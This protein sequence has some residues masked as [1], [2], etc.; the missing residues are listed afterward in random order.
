MDRMAP[1][2][3]FFGRCIKGAAFIILPFA[4]YFLPSQSTEAQITCTP[5]A[6][7][8]NVC[9]FIPASTYAEFNGLEQTIR[10]QYLN[11]LTKSMADASVLANINS[12]MMGPGTVNRFQIGG[13]ISL[14]GVKKDDV[15][16]QYSDISLPKFPNVGASINPGAMV[17]VNLG[18]LL[19][20]GPSDQPDQ[21]SDPSSQRS[22]LHRINIYAHGFQGN[23]GPGDLRKVSNTASNDLDVGGNI[24]SFGATIRFQIAR[25]RYTRL[26]FFGFTGISLGIGFHRKW[27]EVT[28]SYHP[29]TANAIK[30]AFGPATGKWEQEV[31]FSYQSKVQS[32]PIDI[33]TG[34]RLFYILT[35]FAGAGI[36]SNSGYTKLNLH[37]S[38]PLYLALD[39]NASSLP[40]E[41][42]SQM[43]GNAGGTLSLR[44]GGSANVRTQMNYLIGGFEINVLM[45]KILAE[46][47]ATDDKV[48]S[49]NVGVKFAL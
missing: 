16:I 8:N 43:N 28:L 6:S 7:G 29:S 42:I 46:A 23:I 24:N 11:E 20:R 34:V 15:N 37:A 19:G 2:M 32:V 4:L 9:S 13:G 10:T 48:Y 17:G 36:T 44:T 30:V 18:W 27:E 21:S 31:D 5:P 41:L 14:G 39:P 49:A 3:S 45:F 12:S 25:E 35:V 33:R 38:G 22:F 47:V 40:P 26:D 1:T